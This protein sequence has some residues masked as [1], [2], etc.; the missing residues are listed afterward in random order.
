MKNDPKISELIFKCLKDPNL[1]KE[2]K[3]DP[4]R[5]IEK[6]L[7]IKLPVS[8]QLEVL[9]ETPEKGYIVIPPVESLGEFSEEDLKEIAA[10]GFPNTRANQCSTIQGCR[11]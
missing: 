4:K 3:K 11:A 5:L 9:Q 7:N 8:F 6:E 10:G 1:L 2:L